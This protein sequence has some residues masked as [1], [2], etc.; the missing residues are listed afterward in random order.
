MGPQI[1]GAVPV[2][3]IEPS[4][5]PVEP[6]QTELTCDR[7][8]LPGG[9]QILGDMFVPSNSDQVTLDIAPGDIL[10]LG[11]T[12]Q[13]EVSANRPGQIV[14]FDLNPDCELFQIFP[15]FLSPD[16][17]DE[18]DGRRSVEIPNALS[19]NG[20]PMQIRVTEPYGR[21]QL[22]ALLIED[23]VRLVL[24]TLPNFQDV[25][26]I[27]AGLDHL[28]AIAATLNQSVNVANQTRPAKWH[29]AIRQ[30]TISP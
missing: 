24:D 6:Q 17:A 16:G 5:L 10:E 7:L 20:Q 29:A 12:V 13:F 15:S 3:V 21:G 18:F 2:P 19:I 30:Y 28:K 23:D 25:A 11:E 9:S 22:V 14:L 27:P 1:S 8:K 26:P 4:P